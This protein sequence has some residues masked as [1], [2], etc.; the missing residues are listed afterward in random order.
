[1]PAAETGKFTVTEEAGKTTKA[2]T[3]QGEKVFTAEFSSDAQKLRL[4]NDE[5]TNLFYQVTQGGFL[6]DI[7]S[8]E[9]KDGIEVYRE[10]VDTNGKKIDAIKKSK[11]AIYR[12]SARRS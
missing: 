3:P 7:P 10:F 1:M 9:T 4:T 5:K 2:L 12:L 11:T 6:H 8:G